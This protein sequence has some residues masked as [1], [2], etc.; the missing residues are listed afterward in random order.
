MRAGEHPGRRRKGGLEHPPLPSV[1]PPRSP[2][3][4]MSHEFSIDKSPGRVGSAA[5]AVGM[6]HEV[7]KEEG[8]QPGTSLTPGCPLEQ[9]GACQMR[10]DKGLPPA[11]G[12]TKLRPLASPEK[13]LTL[14]EP[15][16][17]RAAG[18]GRRRRSSG[19]ALTLHI[20]SPAFV[21]GSSSGSRMQGSP[22]ASLLSTPD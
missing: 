18:L 13:G 21:G 10:E 8:S 9:K 11:E 16:R 2:P 14:A 6:R 12:G 1:R 5:T 22:A 3:S 19:Q 4:E 20:V 17:S 7:G 15:V